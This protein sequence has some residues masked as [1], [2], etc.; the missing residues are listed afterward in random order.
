MKKIIL[1]ASL[2]L[3]VLTASADAQ[4]QQTGLPQ[5]GSLESGGFDAI[6]HQNLNVGFSIPIVSNPGRGMPYSFAIT[7]NSLIW[8]LNGSGS[9]WTW[10]L[11]GSGWN[12]KSLTG[13][14]SYSFTWD[15][16][17]Y[18]GTREDIYSNYSYTESNGTVHP[19][20]I[21]VTLGAN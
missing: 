16:D 12:Y 6:N 7:Y 9:T 19:F 10:Q 15:M 13:Q 14:T 8:V 21:Y 17:C 20:G 11:L 2:T 4:T 18:L 1:L 5:F 3:T